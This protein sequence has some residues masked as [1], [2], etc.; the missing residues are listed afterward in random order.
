MPMMMPEVAQ[1]DDRI[2]KARVAFQYAVR[3][4]HGHCCAAPALRGKAATSEGR[5]AFPLSI[6]LTQLFLHC[7]SNGPLFTWQIPI[8]P[9]K[10]TSQI[11][12]SRKHSLTPQ[13]PSTLPSLV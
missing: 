10:P 9:P 11:P 2:M 7:S 6:S 1:R 3:A 13:A 5:N 8:H 12:S 4:P